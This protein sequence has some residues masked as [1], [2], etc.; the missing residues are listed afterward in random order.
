MT[1][2]ER[3]EKFK[4]DFPG[5]TIIT[6]YKN[7]LNDKLIDHQIE[8]DY[9]GNVVSASWNGSIVPRR[10]IQDNQFIKDILFTVNRVGLY[11]SSVR[12]TNHPKG[13]FG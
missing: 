7:I 10:L 6:L 12:L 9:D 8:T 11:E 4:V 2:E 3:I 1:P 5:E 13:V